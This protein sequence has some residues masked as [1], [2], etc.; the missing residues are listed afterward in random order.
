MTSRS[1]KKKDYGSATFPF[2]LTAEDHVDTWHMTKQNAKDYARKNHLR[3]WQEQRLR[4]MLGGS[5]GDT[6]VEIRQGC[7]DV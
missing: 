2:K 1:K 6:A 4:E 5:R 7:R 3:K